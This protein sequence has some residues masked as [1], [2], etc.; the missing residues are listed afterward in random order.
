M[1]NYFREIDQQMKYRATE[2][3]SSIPKESES[4]KLN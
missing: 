2:A 4:K 3:N 1:A